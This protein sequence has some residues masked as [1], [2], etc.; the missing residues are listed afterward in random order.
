MEPRISKED[1]ELTTTAAG[2]RKGST[3]D[4]IKRTVSDKL[5]SAADAIE[6]KVRSSDQPTITSYGHQ[7]SRWLDRSADYVRDMDP[8]QMKTAMQDQVRSNP[9]RSLLIAGAV[10]LFLGVLIR[11]R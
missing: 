8:D 5:H 1:T 4:Q 9:G 3:F 6:E 2:E 10:G 11:R 7:A